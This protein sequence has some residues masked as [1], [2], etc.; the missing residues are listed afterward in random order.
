MALKRKLLGNSEKFLSLRWRRLRLRQRLIFSLISSVVHFPPIL[1][2]V[3]LFPPKEPQGFSPWHPKRRY[4]LFVYF[5]Y[6]HMSGPSCTHRTSTNSGSTNPPARRPLVAGAPYGQAQT[7]CILFLAT[8]S[9]YRDQECV[10]PC[11]V[12]QRTVQFFLIVL[13]VGDIVLVLV[14]LGEEL[15]EMIGNKKHCS[16]GSVYFFKFLE[17][18][19]TVQFIFILVLDKTT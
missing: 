17:W 12:E 2:F 18:F 6:N 7:I 16:N 9:M 5:F 3:A 8:C 19:A 10:Y 4:F 15:W 1:I 13:V 11:V 14:D